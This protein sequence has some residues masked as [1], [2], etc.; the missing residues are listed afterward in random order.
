MWYIGCAYSLVLIGSLCFLCDLN[1]CDVYPDHSY[2]TYVKFYYSSNIFFLSL[3]K[4][5]LNKDKIYSN[6]FTILQ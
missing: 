4:I 1:F 6:N 3:L 5:N 2:L